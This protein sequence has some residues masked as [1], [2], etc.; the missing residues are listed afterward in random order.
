RR[1]T[2]FRIDSNG[3]APSEHCGAAGPKM[4]GRELILGYRLDRMQAEV[5]SIGDELT[6]GERLD[7][8][9]QWISVR[10]GELGI[11]VRYHT[12]VSDD[13]AANTA[14]FQ[15]AATRADLIIATGGLGPT[16]D[17]LTREA[18][19]AATHTELL[20]DE[21]ALAHIRGLF[22]RRKRE[23]PERNVVQAMFPAGSRIIPN[24]HGSAPGIDIDIPRA[25]GAPPLA[26]PARCFALPGVP[27][28]MHEMWHQ[29]VAPTILALLGDRRRVIRS[30]TLKCFGVGESD[31]EAMLPDLIRRGRQPTVG[32]T[33]S[34]AT[35]SLRIVAEGC[36]DEECHQQIEETVGTIHACLGS[37]VFGEGSDELPH[38]VVRRM[39]ERGAK[40]ATGEA[41]SGGLM[42]AWLSEADP[43]GGCF[44]GGCV[45]RSGQLVLAA[46]TERLA[47]QVQDQ[48]QA[49]VAL[50]L[51]D[52]P[53]PESPGRAP[54]EFYVTL[55]DG[56]HL[57]SVAYP[58]TGHPDILQAR[59]MKQALNFLRLH[60][61]SHSPPLTS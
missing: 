47:R 7:T 3:I 37:L 10:L 42:A 54:G 33:V 14:V 18:L 19:A 29:T 40:L 49:E 4:L 45:R 50:V 11:R 46:D 6:S 12:T 48:F 23:M 9:S 24:P 39:S 59:A 53:A 43:A 55:A 35:I 60:L 61:L 58:F 30:R 51:G 52:F 13:L 25:A 22:A 32:I 16:A 57:R 36:S 41:G 21:S 56:P 26:A 8:N 27:A 1:Q 44:Q 34:R 38:A 31:L 5:I 15:H 2:R 28:E 17:D 20:L